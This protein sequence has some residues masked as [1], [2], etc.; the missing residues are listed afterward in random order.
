M[1]TSVPAVAL[2]MAGCGQGQEQ[3]AAAGSSTSTSTGTGT[4]TDRDAD[5]DSTTAEPEEPF[6]RSQC[7]TALSG[8]L[9]WSISRQST[10]GRGGGRDLARAS[11]DSVYMLDGCLSRWNEDGSREWEVLEASGWDCFAMDVDP[12]RGPVV[13]GRQGGRQPL[14]AAFEP[15]GA[16][17]WI[18]PTVVEEPPEE[19]PE[20]FVVAYDVVVDDGGGLFVAGTRVP[21]QEP[22]R[23]YA[24]LSRIDPEDGSV[25][26]ERELDE[27]ISVPH[28]T[29]AGDEIVLAEVRRN[30]AGIESIELLTFDVDGQPQDHWS[31]LDALGL[32]LELVAVAGDYQGSIALVGRD[33]SVAGSPFVLAL[34]GSTGAPQWVRSGLDVPWLQETITTVA[35]DPCGS[36]VIAGSG[37]LETA[38]WGNLWVA[39]VDLGGELRWS[40][41]VP[42]PYFSRSTK[43]AALRIEPDGGVLAAGL[44][45]IGAQ[46]TE[47]E[48][49]LFA[50]SWL[51]R[52]RP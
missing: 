24:W 47:D 11:D 23:S 4:D 40:T 48:V 1:W 13:V 50:N 2:L 45:I 22:P 31:S 39:K 10:V 18:M 35:I 3:A 38:D 51:G 14:I 19:L 15:S 9:S 42:A 34:L 6:D 37:D 49:V 29:T 26:W 25:I 20:V 36:V 52:L 32:P 33:H 21:I 7:S 28:L 41:F 46:R 30:A 16:P 5:D 12:A 43:V 8:G 44:E 17:R 27:V